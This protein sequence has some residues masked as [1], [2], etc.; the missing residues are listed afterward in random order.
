MSEYIFLFDKRN[1]SCISVVLGLNR[2]PLILQLS[3]S[4]KILSFCSWLAEQVSTVVN[5]VSRRSPEAHQPLVELID[6]LKKSTRCL[7]HRGMY[8]CPQDQGHLKDTLAGEQ[9]VGLLLMA[10]DQ[11][12]P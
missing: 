12:H 8:C 9:D 1:T 5:K 7:G 2:L 11:A 3:F 4:E 6:S 10:G